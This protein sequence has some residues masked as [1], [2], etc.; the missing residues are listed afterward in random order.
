[1]SHQAE[2]SAHISIITRGEGEIKLA[3][4]CMM[5]VV[6]G[7]LSPDGQVKLKE[8][9][10]QMTPCCKA[11]VNDTTTLVIRDTGSTTCVATS[12]LVKPEQMTGTYELCMLIDGVVKRYATAVVDL[13]TPY[14][15]GMAK[16]LCMDTPVQDIIVGNIPGARGPDTD[17]NNHEMSNIHHSVSQIHH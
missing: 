2:N 11:G 8:W 15:T 6:A 10:S 13:D 3:C 9:R 12:S 7:A 4:G 16:V 5:P 14:Y 1:M 17:I